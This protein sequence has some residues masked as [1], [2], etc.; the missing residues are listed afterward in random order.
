MVNPQDK[1]KEAALIETGIHLST[2]S[3]H[4]RDRFAFWRE[5]V[6]DAYVQLECISDSRTDFTGEIRLN[7]MP[8]ISTSIV[9]GSQQLVRRR[10]H[11]ISKATDEWFLLSIQLERNGLIQQCGR[12]AELGRGDFALYSSID[13]YDLSLPDGFRQLVVQIPRLEL[14]QR[15]PNADLLT[16]LTVSGASEIGGLVRDSVLRL[17][18]AQVT[19]NPATRRCL[20]DSIIDLCAT[21]LT[22]LRGGEA[23]R[24][25][26]ENRLI[27]Q[28]DT[29]IA[30]RIRDPDLD[31]AEIAA[32]LSVSVRR[33]SEVFQAE[34]TS[35]AS[36]IRQLRL[37]GVASDLRNPQFAGWTVSAIAMRWGL[38]NMQHFSRI[39]REHYGITPR[40]YRA[41]GPDGSVRSARLAE[42]PE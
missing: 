23:V 31:R 35:V 6:C 21:G 39:F 15:L 14:L 28:A 25:A 26:T 16:G 18:R 22:T 9:S 27:H 38:N 40:E 29:I 11:D 3:V 7:R 10:R 42:K 4:Q 19:A 37:A 20:E 34:G 41:A 12:M 13:P 33:L 30:Q 2:A 1:T 5:A 32:A 17:I 36:K 8:R 24:T